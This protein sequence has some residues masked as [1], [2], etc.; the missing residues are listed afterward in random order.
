MSDIV[1]LVALRDELPPEAVAPYEV[2][3]TGVGKVNAALTA[4]KLFAERKPDLVINFGTAGAVRPGLSGLID[5]GAAV[6]RD[7]DLRPLGIDLGV[8][9][10]DEEP[11]VIRWGDGPV[12]GTGDSFATQ[13]PEI[14]CDL[15][16][17]E[18]YAL[19]KAA[20]RAGVPFRALKHVSD[21]ADEKAANDWHLNKA[22]GAALF[23]DW[24]KTR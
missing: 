5:C 22:R 10:G 24:L 13:T 16:D 4:A 23:A 12:I 7:M 9:F 21:A 1:I 6:E 3:Y 2:I 18:A 19:A 14:A 17:M 20:S 15:V 8:T 11:A